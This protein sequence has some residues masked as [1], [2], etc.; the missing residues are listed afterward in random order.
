MNSWISSRIA[1]PLAGNLMWR[2]RLPNGF[3]SLVDDLAQLRA[4]GARRLVDTE[5]TADAPRCFATEYSE[6][7]SLRL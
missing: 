6:L 1:F 4:T 3:V 7:V 5:E 2:S